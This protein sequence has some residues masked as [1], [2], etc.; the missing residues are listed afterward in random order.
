MNT[1]FVQNAKPAE[2]FTNLP[3]TI[4]Q[5]VPSGKWKMV[6]GKYCATALQ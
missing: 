1:L 5:T 2:Q 6:N 3:N 4:C